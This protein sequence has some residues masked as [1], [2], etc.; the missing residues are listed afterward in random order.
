MKNI[1]SIY[2]TDIKSII[3]HWV[4]AVIIGGLVLLPSL[5]AWFNI[6]ASWNPYGNTEGIAIAVSNKDKGMT[7]RGHKINIGEEV[8]RSL[9]KNKNLGW[10][11]VDE[12]KAIEGVRHGDY[13]AS[14][15]IPEDFSKKMTTILTGE[16]KKPKIVYYVNE[17]INAIT[18]KM[19]E[20]GATGIIQQV[21]S[22]FVKTATGAMFKVFNELGIE[23]ER[24]W[25]SI[26][27]FEES[28]FKLEKIFPDLK[29]AVNIALKDAEKADEIT[30]KVQKNLV[31]AE[32]VAKD[33]KEF[34]E[35]VDRFL[36]NLK[37]ETESLSPQI[38]EY[39]KTIHQTAVSIEQLTSRLQKTD[40][41]PTVVKGFLSE[42]S[43][44]L[45]TG[46]TATSRLIQLLEQV[47]RLADKPI[48][49][50]EI[51]KLQ[52]VKERFQ[53]QLMIVSKIENAVNKGE[54]PAEELINRWNELSRANK[55]LIESLMN[56]FDQD[57]QP[58]IRRGLDKAIASVNK[59]QSILDETIQTMP[60]VKKILDDAKKGIAT[61]KEELVAI[62]GHLPK[63]QQKINKLADAIRKI[64]A[65]LDADEAIDLL[66]SDFQ[67]ES[68]FFAQPVTLQEVKLFPIPNYGS[69]MS[70]FY[71][72]L[73]L[74]VGA[75][76]LVSLLRTDVPDNNNR[77]KSYQI[78]FGRY[79]T[80]L[81]LALMQAMIVTLGDI[82]LLQAYVANKLWFVLF[83]LLSSAVFM[84]IVY[85][86]VS[87]FGNVGKALSIVLLVL[88]ISGSGGTFPVQVMPAFFQ[89]I[90]PYL[91]FSYAISMMREAVGG[92][93]WGIVLKDLWMMGIF[94]SLA[95]LVGLAL[96]KPINRRAVKL[97][98]NAKAS[99][100]IH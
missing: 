53:Q 42:A 46:I 55:K 92:I 19:T 52:L 6:K 74:W 33:G 88:Q 11:F 22:N 59:I 57:F 45:N 61:G 9:K 27:A 50:S 41:E 30:K 56:R 15:T 36:R 21:S 13:Y 80:F 26:K 79:L 17:K 77:F 43:S 18:P 29:E 32:R 65:E 96:K 70:P 7:L 8:V 75:L 35:N 47:N 28:V 71:T 73:S 62:R 14:I 69:A 48:F 37:K 54:R 72:I 38:K 87:V 63:V 2:T 98:E 10:T 5:Y 100:L 40:L 93:I 68:D 78:Y 86:F 3:K 34:T 89:A 99:E 90:H 94:A 4:A 24:E 1:L 60:D 67:K 91:P 23:L 84:L 25:S 95:L 51:E 44:R 31:I 82:F 20:K 12:K 97:I 66:K 39:V 85:T 16:P 81:T 58:K 64:E 83:G 76:L 49:A